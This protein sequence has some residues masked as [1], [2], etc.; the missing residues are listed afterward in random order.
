[1]PVSFKDIIRIIFFLGTSGPAGQRGCRAGEK[2]EGG[3][4]EEEG[5]GG[6]DGEGP[7]GARQRLR[8]GGQNVR[9]PGDDDLVPGPGGTGPCRL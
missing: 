2:G 8:L 4:P 5:D 6:A 9:L 7:V 1:M 3:G